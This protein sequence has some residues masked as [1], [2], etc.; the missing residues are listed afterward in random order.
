[1]SSHED[2]SLS[3]KHSASLGTEQDIKAHV[4]TKSADVAAQLTAGKDIQLSPED[5]ARIRRKIDWHLMPLMC[6]LYMMQF[7]DKTTLGQSA[8]LGLLQGDHLT[9]NEF[10]WLGTIFYIF[11][12]AFEYP[13]NVAL[14]YLP[15]GKWL[16]FNIFVWSVALLCHAAADTAAKLYVCRIFLGI[17][18]GAITPGFMLVTA[19]FYTRQEQTQRVG[20][21]FLMNG[22]AVIMLGLV[23][24]GT[25]HI[26]AT[27]LMPWQWL[28]IITG[29]ITFV[30]SILFWFFFPDSPATAWFLTPE[31]RVLA[32]ER[33][34]VNQAGVETKHFKSGQFKE[35]LRDPKTWLFFFFAAISN[36]TNSLSNQRQ[37]IVA[38]FGFS[39]ID[40][41]LLG[42][43]DGVVEI[44]VI[45]CT[46]TS[47]TYW[48]NGRAYSGSLAY[49]V[50]I[51]GAILVNALP[52]GDRVGLLFSYWIS[53]T[54]IA[55]FVVGLAWVASTT[56]GHTKRVTTNAIVMIGYGVG[57]AAGPQ[58]W[59][60]KYEPRDHVPWTILAVCWAVSA[61]L[62]LVTRW[63]LARENAKRDRETRD[64]TYDAVYI[65][66]VGA[67][68]KVFDAKVDKAFLDLTD[69]ENRD[70]RYA[71]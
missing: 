68:G 57:N 14:Q 54:S 33:I 23:A 62:L 20:Y 26:K 32:V 59:K 6:I 67:D 3:E 69:Y 5:A 9:Q 47:A 13:Q 8:V 63:H 24:Y 43:V 46:V 29:I 52:S 34:K 60:A 65:T 41:T 15:I 71:L 53:I 16:S 70:F 36:V 49:C 28:M 30:V 31:E 44:I 51:L 12:L 56:A 2:G 10:N 61:T 4:E 37:L 40:T 50:A 18:E 35:C 38:G 17:C 55:P 7:A 58:Y 11:F 39:N 19:M 66:E 22:L 42:C 27:A 45:F 64:E 25:L 1:M 21:W 48:K